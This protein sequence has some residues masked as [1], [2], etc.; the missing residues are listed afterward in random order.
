VAHLELSLTDAFVPAATPAPGPGPDSLARWIA[1]VSEATEPCLVID[2]QMT[3]AA[4]SQSCCDLLG[5]GSPADAVDRPLLDAGVRL[6]DFTAARGELA[7]QDVDKI[8]PL[9]ALTSGRLARGLLRVS[10]NHAGATVS[11]VDA[12]ATPL[13]SEGSVAGSLTF[14]SEV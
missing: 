4:I 8:P 14:L 12:I 10:S 11:T 6:I 13:I 1:T 2:P 9:L 3:I 7:E 5:L